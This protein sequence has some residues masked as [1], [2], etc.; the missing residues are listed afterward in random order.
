M[1]TYIWVVYGWVWIL[2]QHPKDMYVLK[3]DWA[4]CSIYLLTILDAVVNGTRGGTY[5]AIWW[6]RESSLWQWTL[7]YSYELQNYKESGY[8][9]DLELLMTSQ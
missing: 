5:M 9:H 7:R 2:E 8:M 3:R 4:M 1:V 6:P